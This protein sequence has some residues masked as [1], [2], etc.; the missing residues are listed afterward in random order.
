MNTTQQNN[1]TSVITGNQE[2]KKAFETLRY[3]YPDKDISLQT[4]GLEFRVNAE[5]VIK[6]VIEHITRGINREQV[7]VLLPWRSALA[8]VKG[9]QDIGIN[10]FY[11]LSSKRN[12]QTLETEVDF[13]EGEM[14]ENNT[15][16]IADPMLASGNTIIDSIQRCLKKGVRLENIIVSAVLAAPEGANK[17]KCLYPELTIMIGQLDSHLDERGYIVPGLGDFGDKYFTDLTEEELYQITGRL[18]LSQ[19]GIGRLLERLRR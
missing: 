14:S 15:I 9:F 11:H 5:T 10:S 17:I 7:V 16:I 8:Y 3:G 12:E 6:Q 4:R 13:E 2:Y 1:T 19:E 18:N